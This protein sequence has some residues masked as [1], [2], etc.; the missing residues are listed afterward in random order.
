MEAVVRA[1]A[2]GEMRRGSSLLAV[3]FADDP[4]IGHFFVDRRRRR[5]A[6]PSFF[7]AVLHEMADTG[8]LFALETGGS[9]AGV[10]A[11]APPEAAEPG[12]RSRRLARIASLEVDALFPR[13]AR[14]LRA[15]FE[16][17]A[18]SHPTE[19]HWYLAFVGI[20]PAQ[21]RQGL[22][23][24]ILAPVL[25]RADDAAVPCYLETPFPDT[26]AFYRTLGFEETCQLH[27]VPGA[28][29]IWTMTRPSSSNLPS[30]KGHL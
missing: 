15:G 5:L 26:R 24:T 16:T 4:F 27:P 12:D 30:F 10:A 21:Q 23:R 2:A 1:L 13:A 9:L 8:G 11:W 29:A 22:G 14:R 28:P 18:A 20:D 17:L 7:R 25:A 3:A 6:L 19:P